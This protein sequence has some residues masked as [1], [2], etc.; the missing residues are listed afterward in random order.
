MEPETSCELTLG[1]D[2]VR[3]FRCQTAEVASIRVENI[4]PFQVRFALDAFL[5]QQP[6]K[7][8]HLGWSM[9]LPNKLI[10]L[11]LVARGDGKLVDLSTSCYLVP[12]QR[13]R[14]VAFAV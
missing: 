4:F 12:S 11:T 6:S 9:I 1:D 2:V 3:G 7:E 14:K 8:F 5:E 10:V 13:K